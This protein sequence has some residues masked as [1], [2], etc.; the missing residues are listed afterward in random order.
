MSTTK[1]PTERVAKVTVSLPPAVMRELEIMVGEARG[2]RQTASRSEVVAQCIS[3]L[4]A[5]TR[6]KVA[7]P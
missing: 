1:D 7:K 3:K 2:R 5:A 6:P 4:Y